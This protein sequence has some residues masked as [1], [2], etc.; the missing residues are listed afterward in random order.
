MGVGVAGIIININNYYGPFPDSLRLAPVDVLF[1]LVGLIEGCVQTP[2][3][4]RQ[5]MI[6][7]IPNRPL[8]FHQKDIIARDPKRQKNTIAEAF[9]GFD[10]K[11]FLILDK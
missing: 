9:L 6:D 4:N 1:P 5:R 2:N 7:G 3:Y 10:A 8:Y 11:F